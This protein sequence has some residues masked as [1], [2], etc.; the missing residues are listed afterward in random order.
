MPEN[1]YE[2][3]QTEAD[4]INPLSGRVLT[5]NMLFY[6][7][8]AAPW[9]RFV[10]I[11]GFIFIGLLVIGVLVLMAGAGSL[12]ETLGIPSGTSTLLFIIYL[13]SLAIGFVYFLFIYKFGNKIQAYLRSGDNNELENAFKNN[14]SLWTLTGVMFI[15][16]MAFIGL[17]LIGGIFAAIVAGTQ[18]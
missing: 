9:L 1:P 8:G 6:L 18:F 11:A 2:S 12:A 10:G 13:P 14:K 16:S 3:P 7:R 5:E 17:A 15:I 4:A